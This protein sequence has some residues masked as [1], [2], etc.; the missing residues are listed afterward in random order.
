MFDQYTYRRYSVSN[1]FHFE[2]YH[3][4]F[5]RLFGVFNRAMPYSVKENTF[6]YTQFTFCNFIEYDDI[7]YQSVY[8]E[9][10]WQIPLITFQFKVA[11][12]LKLFI[13]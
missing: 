7:Q 6:D 12:C 8:A 9:V 10:K 1:S 5:F 13:S 2:F 4:I 3:N 11:A